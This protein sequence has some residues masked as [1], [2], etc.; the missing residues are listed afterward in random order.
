MAK[1]FEFLRSII[2]INI[3]NVILICALILT[4]QVFD[5]QDPSSGSSRNETA[6]DERAMVLDNATWYPE[7][8]IGDCCSIDYDDGIAELRESLQND[9]YN[10]SNGNAI[11]ATINIFMDTLQGSS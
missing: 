4:P 2:K 8:L 7:E 11:N 3:I 9:H 5:N 6:C 1:Y 10:F